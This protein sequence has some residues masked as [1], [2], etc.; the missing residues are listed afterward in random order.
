M[1]LLLWSCGPSVGQTCSDDRACGD[2]LV[3]QKPAGAANGICSFP[4]SGPGD[5]CLS[6]GD[7]G[8][9]LFCSNDLSSGTRQFAGIC[10]PLQGS[11]GSCFRN[12]NCQPPLVCRNAADGHLGTCG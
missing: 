12:A 4:F 11:D 10:Q 8:A 9:G 1:T 5:R 7:C 3:C 2:E 6:N